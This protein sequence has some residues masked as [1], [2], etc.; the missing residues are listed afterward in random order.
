MLASWEKWQKIFPAGG[1][2]PELSAE[3][4]PKSATPMPR[5]VGVN[6]ETAEYEVRSPWLGGRTRSRWEAWLSAFADVNYASPLR[7]TSSD[8]YTARSRVWTLEWVATTTMTQLR[9]RDVVSRTRRLIP[10]LTA[11]KAPF[12][13]KTISADLATSRTY[14]ELGSTSISV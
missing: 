10:P 6:D 13:A 1:L 7:L 2:K 3:E 5:A 4:A 11:F 14:L 9:V 8:G 12:M